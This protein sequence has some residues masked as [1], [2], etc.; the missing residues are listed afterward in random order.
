MPWSEL[1]KDDL[2]LIPKERYKTKID[3][4]IPL[5]GAARDALNATAR[6]GKKFV[7]TMNGDADLRLFKMTREQQAR[8][9][10]CLSTGRGPAPRASGRNHVPAAS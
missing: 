3:V 4:E 2:W 7:F 10:C 6:L 1:E 9:S 5:S 8:S